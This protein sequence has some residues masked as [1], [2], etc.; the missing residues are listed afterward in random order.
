MKHSIRLKLSILIMALMAGLVVF[1]CVFN[2]VFLE[3]YYIRQQQKALLQAFDRI[4]SVITDE[5]INQEELG[6]VMYDIST[7]QNMTALIVDSNFEKVYSLKA[8]SDKTK[9]WLQDYYFSLSPKESEIISQ[10]NNYVIQTSYNI[11][12]EKSYLEII[13]NDD[14]YMYNIIIQ[15]PLDSISKNVGISNRFYIIVGVVGM[16]VGGVIA[17]FAAG[18]FTKPIKQ[19][20]LTAES[21]A[22]MNFD[23]KYESHDKGEIGM[24]GNSINKMSDNLEHYISDLKAANIELK[25]DIDKR[26]EID[27]MRKDFI[28]NVSHELKT[29]IALIQGY[30]EGLR[31]GVSD[32]PESMQFYC[33]VIVD[34]A[35]KMN[36]MVKQLLTLNQLESGNDPLTIERFDIA[37]HIGEIVKTNQIRVQQKNAAL[38]YE[39]SEPVYVWADQFKIEEVI[40]NYISNAINHVDSVDG[41]AAYIKVSLEYSGADNKK[42]RVHVFN[43]GRPIPEKDIDKIWDKFYKVDKARTRQYGGSGVGLSIVQAIMNSH[44]QSCGAENKDNGVDF[45]F[46]LDCEN[47]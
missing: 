13:G 15:V 44:G 43:T 4:K 42:V 3:K 24:L 21:M 27:N 8:D 17:F 10:S 34:E 1:G 35:A 30:A 9:R 12:D 16:V 7:A 19:L 47:A 38:V 37:K 32:D 5:D 6:Q 39:Y 41:E 23:V 25:K 22:Q 28:S 18:K 20:S 46:E 11:Y 36:N 33:D 29:P 14:N 26:E 2:A 45:W 31:D 40:T